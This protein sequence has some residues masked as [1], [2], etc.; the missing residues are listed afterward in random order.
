MVIYSQD[1]SQVKTGTR[2]EAKRYAELIV[3]PAKVDMGHR[4]GRNKDKYPWSLWEQ[5][6]A[7]GKPVAWL[8][9]AID[10]KTANAVVK[11]SFQKGG[12]QVLE[13][14]VPG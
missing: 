10:P 12:R 1:W 14:K 4:A 3:N 7:I 11:A 2:R 9:R 5:Q 8:I 6:W 13:G